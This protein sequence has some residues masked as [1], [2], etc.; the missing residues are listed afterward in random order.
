MFASTA[1]RRQVARLVI[2]AVI[3]FLLAAAATTL[4]AP[5]PPSPI[6]MGLPFMAFAGA[7]GVGAVFAKGEPRTLALLLAAAG[8]AGFVLIVGLVTIG[9]DADIAFN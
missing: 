6:F 8:I 7:S 1:E 4:F 9:I 3:C 2:I 5:W